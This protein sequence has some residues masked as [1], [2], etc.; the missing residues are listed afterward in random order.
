MALSYLSKKNWHPEKF[1][2]IEAV[3]QAEN[4]EEE[5]EKKKAEHIKKLKEEKHIEDLK[6][7]QVEQGIIPASRLQRLDW[8]YDDVGRAAQKDGDDGENLGEEY[9][10]GKAIDKVGKDEAGNSENLF[11]KT[12]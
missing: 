7:L 9:L 10:L 12:E 1:S 8:M 4:K 11:K 6:R 5:A 3:W 2:N